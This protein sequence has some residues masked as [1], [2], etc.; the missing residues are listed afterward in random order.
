MFQQAEH[1]QTEILCR[2]HRELS[3]NL[4][5]RAAYLLA[6]KCGLRT[7]DIMNLK[8]ENID[9]NDKT[10]HL[11]PKKTKDALIIPFDFMYHHFRH[12]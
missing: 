7:C 2:E 4:R 9:F 1:K 5:N 12:Y 8:F 3:T 6:L 11:V 10:I